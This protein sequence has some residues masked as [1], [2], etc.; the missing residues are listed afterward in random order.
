LGARLGPGPK[1]AGGTAP[2]DLAESAGAGG[3]RVEP[4]ACADLWGLSH[5][6]LLDHVSERV[7]YRR[8]VSAGASVAAIVPTAGALRDDH[9]GEHGCAALSGA[10][11]A[12]GRP[13]AQVVSRR[14]GDRSEVAGKGGADQEPRGWGF[15]ESVRQSVP[16]GR[17][18]ATGRGRGSTNRGEWRVPAA[19]RRTL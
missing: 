15:C 5:E 18:R 16:G 4:G 19:R 13:G 9:A 12:A 3:E 7:G 2:E 11:G 6:L 10:C 14:S 17:E 1:V 8:G